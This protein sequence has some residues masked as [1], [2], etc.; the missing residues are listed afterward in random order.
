MP[1]KRR[2]NGEGSIY[3]RADGYWSAS[4][5]IG[6]DDK[7]KLIRRTITG[8]GYEDVAAQFDIERGRIQQGGGLI[9]TKT[10]I[11]DWLDAWFI[12]A[13]PKLRRTTRDGYAIAIKRIKR[14][15]GGSKLSAVSIKQVNSL[16]SALRQEGLAIATIK[17][18]MS[19]LGSALNRAVSAHMIL[20]NPLALF[21]MPKVE[22]KEAT[23]M[24]VNGQRSFTDFCEKKADKGSVFADIFLFILET[25]LRIGEV[26]ALEWG[27]IINRDERVFIHV[28]QT[29][30]RTTNENE[31]DD[32]KT[33]I[34]I[35]KPK[36]A[37]GERIIP[38]TQNAI[39]IMNRCKARQTVKTDYI[40]AANN[41]SIIQE[42]NIRRALESYCKQ[43]GMKRLTVHELRHTF[44]T[45]M[46]EV[47]I[48]SEERARIMG[49]ADSRTTDRVYVTV[50]VDSLSVA[51]SNYENGVKKLDGCYKTA[52]TM[53]ASLQS[54]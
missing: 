33:R 53:T 25:G 10:T 41:G 12:M 47:G 22:H 38:A 40:F 36:T 37:A 52:T 48:P 19:V 49:H 6:K 29:A 34:Y 17:K 21:D 1:E 28:Q 7:G 45:R 13:S 26:A 24:T 4:I 8:R 18:T 35:G 20:V 51:M 14:Y 54:G 42:R 11:G 32:L 16:Y 23:I 39:R 2:R 50:D 3:Q 46:Y 31:G 9:P 15:I 27:H 44:S 30:A 43:L 5:T